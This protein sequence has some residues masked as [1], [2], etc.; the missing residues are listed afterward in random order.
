MWKHWRT[1]DQNFKW[2]KNLIGEKIE[3]TRKEYTDK[4]KRF[5]ENLKVEINSHEIFKAVFN[6][7]NDE[8]KILLIE[9]YLKNYIIIYSEK[10]NVNY[11]LNEKLLSFLKLIIKAKLSDTHD[12]RYE[13]N[14][15]LQ[16]FI[17]I[18]LFT[19]AYINEIKCFLDIFI[20]VNKYCENI[21]ELMIKILNEEKI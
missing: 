10:N 12:H 11:L 13:F 8:L 2:R 7:N 5:E 9:D 21:E 3:K 17:K 18:V 16:E 20:E 6:Q 15:T 4:I 14:G 19:Q 1:Y